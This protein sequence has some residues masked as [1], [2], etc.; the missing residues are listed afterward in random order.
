MGL[1]LPQGDAPVGS[2]GRAGPLAFYFYSHE[3]NEPPH[4]HVDIRAILLKAWEE[5]HG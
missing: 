3:L 1:S 5:F 4:I 2:I